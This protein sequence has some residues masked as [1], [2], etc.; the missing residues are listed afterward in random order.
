[1]LDRLVFLF[2]ADSKARD[3]S[4][5]LRVPGYMHLKNPAEPFE[6]KRVW[7][8][9]VSYTEEQMI[10]TFPIPEREQVDSKV[11]QELRTVFKSD[12]NNIWERVYNL[13]C[14][15]ALI[16]LSGHP[17]VGCEKFSFRRMSNGNL[18]ILVDSKSTSCWIDR[19]KRIGSLDGGGPGVWQWVN[20]YQ[21]DHKKTYAYMREVFGELWQN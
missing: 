2:G 12:G 11:K 1:M 16:R 8:Y 13:D 5:I 19:D 21:R 17:A 20:W 14:E 15:Q 10:Y 3:L 4:R 7:E 18:N 9:P 6:I